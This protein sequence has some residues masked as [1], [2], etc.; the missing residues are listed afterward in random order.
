MSHRSAGLVQAGRCEVRRKPDL[1]ISLRRHRADELPQFFDGALERRRP[2]QAAADANV[3]AI[4]GLGGE[5]HAGRDADAA[6]QRGAEQLRAID[7]R[8]ATRPTA[9]C[10]PPAARHACRPG[11]SAR[12]RRCTA[13]SSRR[14]WCARVAGTGR[15]RRSRSNARAPVAAA[16]GRRPTKRIWR[17]RSRRGTAGSPPSR[18]DSRARW[19][20]RP[21]RRKSPGPDSSKARMRSRPRAAVV[22]VA[23]DV[24]FDDRHLVAGEDRDDLAL[25]VVRA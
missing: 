6:G 11:S 4:V 16:S 22:Q 24:V 14:A 23:V 18:C 10:R 25:R 15:S 19:S 1:R 21:S 8:A 17:A 13:A 7:A 5:H 12:S 20:W 2:R 3:I 9:R